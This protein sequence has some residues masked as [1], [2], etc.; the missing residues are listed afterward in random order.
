MLKTQYTKYSHFQK[1][2]IKKRNL[3]Q[4]MLKSHK[5]PN[6]KKFFKTDFIFSILFENI[7]LD[8]GVKCDHVF[9]EKLL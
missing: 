6:A 7:Y 9:Y 2:Q 1:M 4:N 8:F 3:C 5:Y